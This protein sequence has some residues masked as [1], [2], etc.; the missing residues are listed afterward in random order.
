M[1]KLTKIALA[2]VLLASLSVK[3]EEAVLEQKAT[4]EI[5]IE[6]HQ[7]AAAL[8]ASPEAALEEAV[9]SDEHK[10]SLPQS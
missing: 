10:E 2:M 4:E 1:S 3:A 9:S 7:E 8:E 6:A 5:K